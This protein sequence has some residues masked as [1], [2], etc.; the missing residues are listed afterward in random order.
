MTISDRGRS[1]IPSCKIHASQ[2]KQNWEY[3]SY[4]STQAHSSWN[5]NRASKIVEYFSSN[6]GLNCL[7][8][9]GFFI[10]IL[11]GCRSFSCSSI[12]P[13][14]RGAILVIFN[15]RDSGILFSLTISCNRG[16]KDANTSGNEIMS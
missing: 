4:I 15:W 10:R 8:G 3:N 11:N 13:F 12:F 14:I 7:I 6:L 5:E 9:T 1:S 16:T 2:D